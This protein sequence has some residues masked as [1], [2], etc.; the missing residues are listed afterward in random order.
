MINRKIKI[1]AKE[2]IKLKLT[3][4]FKYNEDSE[5]FDDMEIYE[6]AFDY[7]YFLVGNQ[8]ELASNFCVYKNHTKEL[9]NYLQ[10]RFNHVESGYIYEKLYEIFDLINNEKNIKI[11]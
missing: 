8:K 10:E 5:F 11:T 4:H 3:D 6:E 7:A 1:K 2:I 9:L